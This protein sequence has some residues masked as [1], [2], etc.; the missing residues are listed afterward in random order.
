MSD[1]GWECSV[2]KEPT[3]SVFV[4]FRRGQRL[5][6]KRFAP[7]DVALRFATQVRAERFHNHDDVFIID[8]ASGERVAEESSVPG[9]VVETFPEGGPSSGLQKSR[10]DEESDLELL[11]KY[12]DRWQLRHAHLT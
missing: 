2:M 9:G 8:D 11:L 3:Y 5:T 1:C 7:L 12:V 6:L 10:S 4:R